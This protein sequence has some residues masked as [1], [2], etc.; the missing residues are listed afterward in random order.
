LDL[1]ESARNAGPHNKSGNAI[2]SIA[3][4]LRL[5]IP[6]LHVLDRSHFFCMRS[7]D[8]VSIESSVNLGPYANPKPCFVPIHQPLTQIPILEGELYE[9]PT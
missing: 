8:A 7:W 5:L 9:T 2:F 6:L 1:T 4:N 3:G